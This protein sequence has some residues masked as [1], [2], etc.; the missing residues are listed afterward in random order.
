MNKPSFMIK[1]LK[2]D[3]FKNFKNIELNL[4]K[5]NVV[6]GQNASGKSNLLQIFSFIKDIVERGISDAIS[7]QGGADYICN[8]S[9]KSNVLKIEI[10]FTSDSL[11]HLRAIAP[12][13]NPQ[14]KILTNN[15]IYKLS[16]KFG[17]NSTFKILSDELKIFCLYSDVIDKKKVDYKGEI[18][19]NKK[20][21]KIIRKYIFSP[22]AGSILQEH[23]KFF[24][25]SPLNKNQLLLEVDVL[26][27]LIEGWYDILHGFSVHDFDP[28]SLKKSST[29][30]SSSKLEYDGSNI[31]NIL[32]IIQKDKQALDIFEVYSKDLLSFYKSVDTEKSLDG[33]FKF[34]LN[35]NNKIKMPAIF[36]SDGTVNIFALILALFLQNN[37][38]TAIEEPERNIH[39]GLLSKLISHMKDVSKFNQLFIT[40]HN[41]EIL[42]YVDLSNM[43]L[44]IR[45]SDGYSIIIKPENHRMVRQ[46]VNDMKIGEM[47]KQN[48]LGDE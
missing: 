41:P 2:V 16:I 37:R 1:R 5:F 25:Y 46:F 21:E 30:R 7:Y 39:P 22:E 29:R 23:Y 8:L 48:M 47:M 32:D 12:R 35:E 34:I 26:G 17:K 19:I 43:F 18:I 6:I 28:K 44:V 9:T 15:L 24:D 33:S 38:F 4:E 45:K 10:E 42:K 14:A 31:A 20:G 11:H 13:R 27:F 40:T 3:N 36:V